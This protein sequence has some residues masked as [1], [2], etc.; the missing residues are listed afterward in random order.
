M[1]VAIEAVGQ[2]PYHVIAL[3][4]PPTSGARVVLDRL[5]DGLDHWDGARRAKMVENS[6]LSGALLALVGRGLALD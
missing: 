6:G 1:G 3:G 4:V 2:H 5:L